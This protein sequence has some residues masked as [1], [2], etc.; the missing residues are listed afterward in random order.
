M[1]SGLTIRC[2]VYLLLYI[3]LDQPSLASNI[4]L[5]ITALII[6]LRHGYIWTATVVC[7]M[8]CS[9]W[10]TDQDVIATCLTGVSTKARRLRLRKQE[11]GKLSHASTTHYFNTGVQD[12]ETNAREKRVTHL[13][14]ESVHLT[15][16]RYSLWYD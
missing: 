14:D 1:T 4:R 9:Q 6:M 8:Y 7:W 10:W 15:N 3:S 16:K 13:L 12:N 5:S 2:Y 11:A